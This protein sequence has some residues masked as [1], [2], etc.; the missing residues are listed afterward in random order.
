MRLK[1]A[2]EIFNSPAKHDVYYRNSP[3][4][5]D[6]IDPNRDNAAITLLETRAKMNV[7]IWDLDER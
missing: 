6:N 3:V 1:R 2:E 4:W 5:I 7:P